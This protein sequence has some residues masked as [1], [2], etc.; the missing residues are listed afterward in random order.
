MLVPTTPKLYGFWYCG[1]IMLYLII[2]LFLYLRRHVGDG[3][4]MPKH[5]GEDVTIKVHQ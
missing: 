2:V 5:V 4:I 3:R 1:V